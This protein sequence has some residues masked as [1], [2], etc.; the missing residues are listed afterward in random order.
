MQ[1]ISD[2]DCGGNSFCLFGGCVAKAGIGVP[3]LSVRSSA[4]KSPLRS[5]ISI[6]WSPGPTQYDAHL[7]DSAVL[8]VKRHPA[9]IM[10][11]S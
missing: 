11:G 9:Q 5:N 7:Y 2:G 8:E 1:C 3:C 10:Q 4:T 6:D